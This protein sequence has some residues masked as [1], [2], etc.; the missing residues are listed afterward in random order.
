MKLEI[1]DRSKLPPS[2]SLGGYI[3]LWRVVRKPFPHRMHVGHFR[4]MKQAL[5]HKER[6]ETK[7]GRGW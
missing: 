1:D 6:L 4:S 2:T 5:A 3:V 7:Y